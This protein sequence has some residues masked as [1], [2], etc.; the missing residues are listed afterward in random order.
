MIPFYD[1]IITKENFNE[2][3]TYDGV[4]I[5]IVKN[6]NNVIISFKNTYPSNFFYFI[7]KNNNYYLS[8]NEDLLASYLKDNNISE[9]T[10]NKE[11]IYWENKKVTD[12]EN[13]ATCDLSCNKYYQINR[14]SKLWEEIKIFSNCHFEVKYYD[15]NNI[16]LHDINFNDS[17]DII[18]NWIIKY[19]NIIKNIDE[20]NLI[21]ELSAGLDSRALT[22]FWRYNDKKYIIY[23]K[24]DDDELNIVNLLKD[25]LP[26]KKLLTS[27]KGISGI[28]LSG[29]GNPSHDGDLNHYLFFQ[30]NYRGVHCAKHLIKDICPYCDKDYLRIKE[31]Y[32][33]QLK[34]FISYLLSKDLINI[35]YLTTRKGPFNFSKK[36][37]DE[38]ESIIKSWNINIYDLLNE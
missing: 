28:T 3:Y 19:K 31:N 32:Y 7:D 34:Y 11:Y 24:N 13:W 33:H 14:I 18:I 20:N 30:E 2:I 17:K 35:P 6:E 4:S 9:I 36:N 26:I 12:K 1:N 10:Y 22:A 8:L 21:V 38:Y 5:K 37:I 23:S 27:K 25:K 15:Y 29:L 16:L